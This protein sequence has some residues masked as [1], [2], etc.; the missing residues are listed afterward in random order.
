MRKRDC[1]TIIL[2]SFW[3]LASQQLSG[4]KWTLTKILCR[5][6]CFLCPQKWLL[7]K[8]KGNGFPLF[9]FLLCFKY[10]C[11]KVFNGSLISI[12]KLYLSFMG[13]VSWISSSRWWHR[14]VLNSLPLNTPNLQLHTKKSLRR[15]SETSWPSPTHQEEKNTLKM[16][17]RG[18]D[19][20]STHPTQG[21]MTQVGIHISELLPKE[22]RIWI[23]H[24][25]PHF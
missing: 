16:G 6:G 14:R 23:P 7:K 15:D 21:T 11:M 1:K 9:T 17:G 19:S 25:L 18:W 12:I 13:L 5:S 10:H 8:A 3:G 2:R 24:L 22:W 20:L 4:L